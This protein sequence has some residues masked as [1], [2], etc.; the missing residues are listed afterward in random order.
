MQDQHLMFDLQKLIDYFLTQEDKLEAWS[1]QQF[2]ATIHALVTVAEESGN[3]PGVTPETIRQWHD[4]YF[5]LFDQYYDAESEQIQRWR[6]NI[7]N[8]F[9]RLEN[10]ASILTSESPVAK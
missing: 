2:A 3:A 6:E 1:L 4:T 5:T 7:L 10:A 8:A 9:R